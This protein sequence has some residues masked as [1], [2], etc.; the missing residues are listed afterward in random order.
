LEHEIAKFFWTL[1]DTIL[2]EIFQ[3]I[4]GKAYIFLTCA[5]FSVYAFFK[6]KKKAVI[7]IIAAV[8]SVAASDL[9]CYR[10]LKPAIKRPRPVAELSLD[11]LQNA[12]DQITSSDK[13]DYSMPSNHASNIFAFFIVYFLSVKKFWSLLFINSMLISLSRVI[14]VKHYPSDVLAGIIAGLIIGFAIV[15]LLYLLLRKNAID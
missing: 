2:F 12:A 3:I 4:S 11:K 1:K 8:L 5:A 15:K 9:L 10:I 6:L 13:Q 14:L 7:F